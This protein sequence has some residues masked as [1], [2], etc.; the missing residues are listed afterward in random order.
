MKTTPIILAACASFWLGNPAR[1]SAVP[2]TFQVNLEYQITN[3]LPTFDPLNDTVEIRGDFNGTGFGSGFPLVPAGSTTLYTNTVDITDPVPGG[4]VQFKFHTY[5][6][7]EDNWEN[8]PGYIYTNGYAN[9]S[10]TL[11]SSAQTLPP[12]SFSDQWGGT[13][14]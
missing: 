10:F 1:M 6:P 3:A 12:V 11:A 8:L 14:P 4:L 7:S 2:V 9:R 5:G 13:V